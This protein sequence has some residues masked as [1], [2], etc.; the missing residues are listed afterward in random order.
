M[1]TDWS[2]PEYAR[3]GNLQRALLEQALPD[4]PL[5]EHGS[6]LDIGCGDGVLT[7]AIAGRIPDGLVVG[8]DPSPAMIAVAQGTTATASG[9]HFVR[10]DARRLPFTG[11]FD[12][13]VSFNA[14]HWVPEQS[15][16]LA[17]IA[18]VLATGGRAV[19]QVV[20]AGKA[21]SL[22]ALAMELTRSGRWAAGFTDFAAPFV[23]V[24]PAHY[25]DFAAVA[26]LSV[27]DLT[28]TDREWDFGSHDAFAR[29]CGVGITAWT[30][31]LP[32]HDRRDFTDD[33]IS[34][35]EELS[36]RPGV[37]GFTQMRAELQ[38]R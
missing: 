23:H 13:V 26:G 30:D 31:R 20:C 3:V 33:L 32:E 29:W 17:E 6:V 1:A 24:D 5:V 19:V 27:T 7:H 21:T 36:G 34:V 11:P 28:V 12:T 38:H 9:P 8:L 25:E 16:A 22:E 37:F 4:L 35:Y 14:L 15:A 10:A 18:R 2:G